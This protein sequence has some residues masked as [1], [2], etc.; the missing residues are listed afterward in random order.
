MPDNLGK[1]QAPCALEDS[2]PNAGNTEKSISLR[3][4]TD[5]EELAAWSALHREQMRVTY[6]LAH[7]LGRQKNP[8]H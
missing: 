6:L 7:D 4:L 3:V 5:S 2:M 8:W 1:S